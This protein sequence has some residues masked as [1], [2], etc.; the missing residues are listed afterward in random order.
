MTLLSTHMNTLLNLLQ[1]NNIDK[2]KYFLFTKQLSDK[3][4]ADH[5]FIKST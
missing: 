5:A 4:I 3:M 2:D 1:Q